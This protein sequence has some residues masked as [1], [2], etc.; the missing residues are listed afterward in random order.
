MIFLIAIGTRCRSA[1]AF[2][3]VLRSWIVASVAVVVVRIAVIAT[4]LVDVRIAA[5]AV[6]VVTVLDE[7]FASSFLGGI[8]EI[9]LFDKKNIE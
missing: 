2:H 5:V 1:L 6:T 3:A 4:T 7:A 9:L 8:D